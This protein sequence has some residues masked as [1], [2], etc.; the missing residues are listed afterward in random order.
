M[1]S[2][3]TQTSGFGE[4]SSSGRWHAAWE[5]ESFKEDKIDASFSFLFH[6]RCLVLE[7]LSSVEPLFTSVLPALV[8]CWREVISPSVAWK[9]KKQSLLLLD[10]QYH[11]LSTLK[12]AVQSLFKIYLCDILRRGLAGS[13]L[14]SFSSTFCSRLCGVTPTCFRNRQM[15]VRLVFKKFRLFFR[16]FSFR[17]QVRGGTVRTALYIITC[18]KTIGMCAITFFTLSFIFIFTRGVVKF[19]AVQA[20]P[21]RVVERVYFLNHV[22]HLYFFV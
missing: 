5:K 12:K 1:S 2:S 17:S 14:H 4:K 11:V 22:Q 18:T 3:E 13:W 7:E 16:T 9:K 6:W 8:G 10:L 20:P 15:L 21:G 19:P